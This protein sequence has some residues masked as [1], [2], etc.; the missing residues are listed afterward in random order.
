[1][2]WSSSNS[3]TSGDIQKLVKFEVLNYPAGRRRRS[4]PKPGTSAINW[5]L[6][7]SGSGEVRPHFRG[8]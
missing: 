4:D 7:E 3:F 6:L 1:L 5:E 2:E 8:R